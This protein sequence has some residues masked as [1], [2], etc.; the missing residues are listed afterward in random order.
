MSPPS[1]TYRHVSAP[2]RAAV[3]LT[4]CVLWSL[5]SG[6]AAAQCELAELEPPSGM[7]SASFG[8]AVAIHSDQALVGAP[9]PG[10]FDATGTVHGFE[11]S[12]SFWLDRGSIK[13]LTSIPDDRFGAALASES[14]RAIVGAPGQS[15]LSVDGAA[16]IFERTG[17]V[18]SEFARLEPALIAARD[19]FGTSVAI[20]GNRVLVGAPGNQLTHSGR[21][22]VF[23]RNPLDGTWS[24]VAELL[25]TG[26]LP[27]DGFGSAVALGLD[28]AVIG[29]PNGTGPG[30]GPPQTGTV[31]VFELTGGSW[32]ETSVLRPPDGKQGDSFG[33]VVSLDGQRMAVGAPL[34]TEQGLPHGSV[35]LFRTGLAGWGVE[36]IPGVVPGIAVAALGSSV[37]LSGDQLLAGD[38]GAVVQ[39]LTGAGRVHSFRRTGNIWLHVG[40]LQP[41]APKFLAGFGTSLDHEGAIVLAG[42]SDPWGPGAA[43]AF[44]LSLNDC[45]ALAADVNGLS[46]AA[47]GTQELT[48]SAGVANA[49]RL[50]LVLGSTS[51]TA[52]GV[53]IEGF[54]LPLN[55]DS[56]LSYRLVAPHLPPVSGALGLLNA[57]GSATARVEFPAGSAATLA[58]IT[59][60]HAYVVLDV[61][62]S[63]VTS[64]ASNAVVLGLAP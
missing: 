2:P 25:P 38:P 41:G 57:Q 15:A 35:Y 39:G 48:L 53:A 20:L 34:H 60:N 1:S 49:G 13:P 6:S 19:A 18:W 21:A 63:G 8:A 33:S 54:V 16:Y 4:A 10:I 32:L 31:H 56:Y 17:S 5:V 23:E 59:L 7:T 22:F 55:P 61:F 29:A 9:D 26:G 50:Y 64:F 42:S 43:H 14:Q 28:R 36:S 30:P 3:G 44:S 45:P 62:G 24:E 47:G 58:G 51:G 11:K 12:G 40:V 52:P 27:F 46:L 37:S